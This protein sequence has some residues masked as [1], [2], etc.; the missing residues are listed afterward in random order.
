M[1]L[2]C[3]IG[4][5]DPRCEASERDYVAA[6]LRSVDLSAQIFMVAIAAQ[7]INLVQAPS[8]E[9]QVR[10]FQ[11]YQ[12]LDTVEHSA[13]RAPLAHDLS[14]SGQWHANPRWRSRERRGRPGSP[15]DQ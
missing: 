4:P 15:R 8:A 6:T 11:E 3:W 5:F 9:V 7:R 14:L 2:T 10:C 12:V 13:S 1:R